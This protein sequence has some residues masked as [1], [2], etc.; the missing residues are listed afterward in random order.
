MNHLAVSSILI[1]TTSILSLLFVIQ[2]KPRTPLKIIWSLFNFAVTCWALCFFKFSVSDNSVSALFWVRIQNLSAIFIPLFFLHFVLLLT[3]FIRTKRKEL[4][5]YYFLFIIYFIVCLLFPTHFVPDISPKLTLPYYLN[6]G[7]LYYPFPFVYF[8]TNIYGLYLLIKKYATSSLDK[9]M[10]IIYV[11]AGICIG[12]IGG[13]STFLL[14]FDIPIYP[15]GIYLV[16]IYVITTTYAIIKHKLMNIQIIIKR[17]IIY[18][19]SLATIS[20]LYLLSIFLL[21]KLAQEVFN[22]NSLFIS[23]STAFLL[24]VLF[25]PLRQKIQHFMDL[26]FFKG[27]PDEIATQNEK[28][29][30]DIAQSEKYK[31]LSTFATGIAHEVKNNKI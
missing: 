2:H 11:F 7:F 28:L 5:F 21:E 26:Y 4:K 25:I 15:W 10:Q 13:G 19:I 12:M 16:P 6:A 24:G 1:F 29:R 27:T 9:Q 14:V 31:T 3:D 23:V 18:S 30:Q 20:I 22:Y 8:I 17:S